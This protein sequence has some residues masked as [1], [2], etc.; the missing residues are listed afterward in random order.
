MTSDQIETFRID[1]IETGGPMPDPVFAA[2]EQAL[3]QAR[4]AEQLERIA[5]SLLEL[6]PNLQAAIFDALSNLGARK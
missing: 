6:G 5:F 3:Q 4:I 2:F 1:A